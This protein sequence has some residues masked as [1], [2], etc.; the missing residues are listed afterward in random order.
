MYVAPNA[1]D[2]IDEWGAVLARRTDIA[3]E[4]DL[5]VRSPE[6]RPCCCG[7]PISAATT[8]YES[9]TFACSARVSLV[10]AMDR[11]STPAAEASLIAKA[12]GD[13]DA[14][15]Q[16][17]RQHQARVYAICLRLMTNESD[18]ARCN[19]GI[20]DCDLPRHYAFD[21]RSAFTTW[22]YRVTTNACLDELRRRTADPSRWTRNTMVITSWQ[23]LPKVRSPIASRSTKRSPACR[24]SFV[25]PSCSAKSCAELDYREIAEVLSIPPGTVRSRIARGRTALLRDIGNQPASDES[26]TTTMNTHD[27]YDDEWLSSLFDDEAD[28]PTATSASGA[29]VDQSVHVFVCLQRMRMS[30][31][32][33]T[34]S[35]KRASTPWNAAL[36][37]SSSTSHDSRGQRS[38][39]WMTTLVGAAAMVA[40][41]IVGPAFYRTT[42][43]RASRRWARKSTL[44]CPIPRA[45]RHKAPKALTSASGSGAALDGASTAANSAATGSSGTAAVKRRPPSS[46]QI[47][48]ISLTSPLAA[49]YRSTL[50]R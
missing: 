17:L 4:T 16:L 33:A 20:P 37:P 21:A 19:P 25:R 7:S 3:G 36:A 44:N 28:L 31:R 32:R 29:A 14:L 41:A 8:K 26:N 27:P 2:A 38:G 9:A 50:A 43:K 30:K 35:T 46:V 45:Q 10:D 18:A 13:G 42:T 15:D 22:I 49:R 6:D 1:P 24:S 47:S 40:V 34:G 5:L 12:V 39:R 11:P 23:A 48:A